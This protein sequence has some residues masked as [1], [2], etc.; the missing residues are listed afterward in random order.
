MV[1]RFEA[2]VPERARVGVVVGEH[3]PDSVLFGPRL[4]RRLV[5]LPRDDPLGA[6]QRLG[7]RWVYFGRF[8]RVPPSPRGWVVEPLGDVGTLVRAREPA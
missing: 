2:V 6:A 3:D 1:D 4:Q 7:L 5:V 8:E